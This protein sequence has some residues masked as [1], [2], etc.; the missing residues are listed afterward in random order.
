MKRLLTT[1]TIIL[2]VI[3]TILTLVDIKSVISNTD[4]SYSENK[5]SSEDEKL[6][7]KSFWEIIDYAKVRSGTDLDERF[8]IIQSELSKYSPNDILKFA[9]ILKVYTIEAENDIFLKAACK[10]IE[11]SIDDRTFSHFCLWLI[12][13]GE[14]IY[15]NALKNPDSLATEETQKYEFCSFEELPYAPYNVYGKKETRKGEYDVLLTD[16]EFKA[17]RKE[18]L[19]EIEPKDYSQSNITEL[20]VLELIPHTVP[21]LAELY[22]YNVSKE[23]KKLKNSNKQI[24]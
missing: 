11:G 21:K 12:S 13:E 23:I 24:E 16:E 1:A 5:V 3:L 8:Y 22:N 17:L 7:R 9:Q 6:N 15:M 14:D 19:N 10:V 4:C 18:L 2:I 20:S